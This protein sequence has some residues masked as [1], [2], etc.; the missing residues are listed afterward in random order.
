MNHKYYMAI[1]VGTTNWKVSVF[2]ETGEMLGIERCP[3][4]THTDENGNSYYKPDEIW[5]TIKKLMQEIHRKY[6][7]EISAISIASV[8]E[9]VVPVDSGGE[10]VDNI[11]T[12][13]D[14]RSFEE[15]QELEKLLGKEKLFSITGLDV[16]PIFSLPKIMWVRK[17]KPS[18]YEAAAK[19]LQLSDFI[20]CK[21]TGEF[22]TDYT[23]ACRTLAFNVEQNDWSDEI[24]Q[25]VEME[26]SIFPNVM[27]SGSI[28]GNVL[29]QVCA[30][31][32]LKNAP[33]VVLGG[34]DHPVASIV[35]GAMKDH[36]VLDSSGTAEAYLYISEKNKKPLME[37]KGQRTGRYLTK[38]R[39]VLWGGIIASGRSVDWARSVFA[40]VDAFGLKQE[41]ATFDK[42]LPMLEHV[43]GVEQGLIY[44][45]HL[46]GA[47][48]PYWEPR[49]RGSFVGIR[50]NMDNRNFFRAVLE[51]LCMQS[52]MIIEMHENVSGTK[53][54]NICVVGGS[55]KNRLWQQLKANIT[56]KNVE[57][58][59]E[60]EATS[61]G[62]AM[63]AA[64]G[65][66]MYESV[67]EASDF[68]SRNNEVIVPDEDSVDF[69]KP[70]Y[71]LYKEGYD[72][73]EKINIDIHSLTSQ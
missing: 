55:S 69:Y 53:I 59:F 51:G 24:L 72:A 64:I 50:D 8:A 66:G 31:V 52:K 33:K 46:R 36:K 9:A 15:A 29:P 2:D 1:D 62:A 11:I 35:T 41:K 10:A 57:L 39:Y 7:V 67:E 30:E 12:W 54:N 22:C 4:K 26:R 19:W 68:L 43:K 73:L 49:I 5:G 23:L 6:P 38:D 45:P 40:S 61:L 13:F 44:Y 42:I 37:F 3:T 47:G 20:V 25:T 48:A 14:T 21:L 58:C 65:E 56:G 17:H 32:G 18:V 27:E 60:P 34:H 71:E 70:Y 63:L 28:I 16:N